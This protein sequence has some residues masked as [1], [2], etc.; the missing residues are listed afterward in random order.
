[1]TAFA[2]YL[3]LHHA[4]LTLETNGHK[5]TVTPANRLN[6]EL[7]AGIRQHKPA[8]I[9]L[10]QSAHHTTGRLLDWAVDLDPSTTCM[11]PHLRFSSAFFQSFA[12]GEI[13]EVTRMIY[14]ARE[15]CVHLIRHEA[16]EL[17][18]DGVLGVK[19]HI[20]EIGSGLIVHLPHRAEHGAGPRPHRHAGEAERRAVVTLGSLASRQRQQL[21]RYFAKRMGADRTTERLH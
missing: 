3:A 10:L 2:L 5:L 9:E 4:G 8:L 18:A 1:M 20:H 11:V 13:D 7:R 21:E 17:G 14:D 19:L 15:N 16:E 12:R 6:D